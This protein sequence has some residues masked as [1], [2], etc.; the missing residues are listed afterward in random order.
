[1]KTITLLK[2]HRHAGRDYPAGA[3]LDLPA[4]KA[5]WLIGVGVAKAA[6]AA[7]PSKFDKA[8]KD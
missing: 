4:R 8:T 1:M 6:S 5:D 2:P 7:A 3:A